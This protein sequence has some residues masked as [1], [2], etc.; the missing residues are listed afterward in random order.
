MFLRMISSFVLTDLWPT[1]W[2]TIL[3]GIPLGFYL[4]LVAGRQIGYV[5]RLI[6]HPVYLARGLWLCPQCNGTGHSGEGLCF[7]CLQDFMAHGT[8]MGMV[9]RKRLFKNW[10]WRSW[11]RKPA[12]RFPTPM[13]LR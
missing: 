10:Q 11:T 13:S 3:V 1:V 5:G 9:N 6:L 2:T 8:R 7:F 12:L 4:S